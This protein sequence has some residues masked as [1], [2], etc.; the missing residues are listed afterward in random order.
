[1][2]LEAAIDSAA[3]AV[4]VTALK[5]LQREAIRAFA[6]GNDVFVS[7]PT[8]YGKSFCF[9]LL[10]LVLDRIHSRSGSIVL[11][12]SQLTSLMVEQRTKFTMI[13]LRCEFVSELQKDLE[14]MS[15]VQNGLV[16]L[17]FISPE[18]LYLTPNGGRCSVLLYIRKE[19]WLL[20]LMKRIAKRCGM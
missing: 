3:E 19:W 16:Q 20:L 10:L 4:G 8:G 14:S 7:L 5:S 1:M 15:D 18:S 11:C 13:G 12:I 2:E 6:S 17:L 9:A